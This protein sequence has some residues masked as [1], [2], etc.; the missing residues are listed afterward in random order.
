MN[1]AIC[2]LL[3]IACFLAQMNTILSSTTPIIGPKPT[4]FSGRTKSWIDYDQAINRNGIFVD[5]DFSLLKCK[6]PPIVFTSL[7]GTQ[8]HWDVTGVSSIYSLTN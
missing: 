6:Q 8:F 5:V 2:F 3:L 4:Y 7:T 1:S